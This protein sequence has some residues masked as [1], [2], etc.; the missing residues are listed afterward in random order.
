VPDH[1]P[2]IDHICGHC[3]AVGV[4]RLGTCSVCGFTVCRKC[5]NVQHIRGEKRVTHDTCLK[6]DEGGFS[7]IKFVR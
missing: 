6:D 7:M 5:G 3:C 1:P 4:V 2:G